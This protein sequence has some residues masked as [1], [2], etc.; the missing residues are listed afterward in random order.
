MSIL[1]NINSPEQVRELDKSQLPELCAELRQFLI[2]NVSKT[3]GHLASNLGAVELTVAIHRVYDTSRDRIV[4]DVGHQSYVHKI[5]TGRKDRFYSLRTLGGISGFPKPSEAD[6][7]SFIAGHASN[8]ISA[9][10]GMARARTIMHEDYSVAAVIGDGA[11]TGGLA[12][13]GLND[14]GE[15][16]EPLVVILNDNGMSISSNVGGVARLLAR[17]RVRPGYINFKRFYRKTVG[18]VTPLYRLAHDI[19]EKLKSILLHTG[20]FED[21]GFNYLGP[22]DGH[23]VNK[24]ETVLRWAK[25]LGEPVLLHVITCK[26]KGYAPAEADPGLYHGVN[27]FDPEKGAAV[28]ENH[29]FSAVFGEELCRL[30]EKNDR[31]TAITA[32]MTDGTGLTGFAGRFPNRFFDVGIAEGHAV[33]MAAGMAKQ[34]LVPV[35][36]IYSSFLQRAYDMLLHDVSLLDLHVVLGVDRAGIVGRD[37]ETHNGVFDVN[38]LTSIPNMAIF[39]PSSFA[40]LRDMLRLAVEK[41]RG[42][43]AVRYPRGGE[44]VYRATTAKEPV[45]VLRE[46]HDVCIITYGIMIN[47]CL[48]ATKLLETRGHSVKLIKLNLINPLDCGKLAAM[49]QDC[50][51]LLVVEDEAAAGCVGERILCAAEKRGILFERAE[52]INLGKGVVPHGGPE[53]LYSVLGLDAE[54]IANTAEDMLPPDNGK[55]RETGEEAET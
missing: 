53:R 49:A 55:E 15:S 1:E 24:L 7:D 27:P 39:C 9:A 40:E 47:Q 20:M 5:L 23:D 13:E 43:V 32:A 4:F 21:M 38:Y 11:L 10:L 41:V 25:E 26:G 2:D 14:A 33:T 46:G 6:D 30:A 51:R 18:R 50:G 22:V 16:G 31:I 35:A 36:A 45:A 3:G 48:K 54:S 44:G 19:K 8:S 42:P 17:S 52:L 28:Q 34:G 29:D 37:G 12:Y